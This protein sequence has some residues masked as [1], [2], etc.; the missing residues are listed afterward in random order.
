MA[1]TMTRTRTQTALTR[2]AGIVAN[3]NGELAFVE[4]LLKDLPD[5]HAVLERRKAKLVADRCAFYLTLNQFDPELDPRA[6]GTSDE[7]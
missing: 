3:I 5:Y 2:L 7:W 6:I 4:Q 1:L